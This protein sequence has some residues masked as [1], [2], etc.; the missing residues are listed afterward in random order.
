MKCSY[1]IAFELK[2]RKRVI[3]ILNEL[4]NRGMTFESNFSTINNN[5]LEENTYYSV[6]TRDRKSVV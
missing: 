1:Y 4:E 6:E 3:P 2:D 5:I